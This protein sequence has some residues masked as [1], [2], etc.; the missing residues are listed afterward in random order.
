MYAT[1]HTDV[2]VVGSGIAGLRSALEAHRMGADVMIVSKKTCGL[3]NSSALSATL[4]NIPFGKK[5]V[6]KHLEET[7]EAG[8]HINNRRL[9]QILVEEA[10]QEVA[11]LSEF[12][13]SLVPTPY[14]GLMCNKGR[15]PLWGL[16]LTLP[17][18]EAVRRSQIEILDNTIVIDILISGNRVKGLVGFIPKDNEFIVIQAKSV[19]LA[20]GGAGGLYLRSDNPI[21]NTGDGYAIAYRAGAKLQDM[22]FVQ[23]FPMATSVE[24]LPTTTIPG[25][26]AD[27]GE[28]VNSSGE[29]IVRKHGLRKP[30]AIRERDALSRTIFEEILRGED[31]FIDLRSLDERHWSAD[32]LTTSMKDILVK[33][34]KCYEKPI[35]IAPICH[36]T[37]GGISINEFCETGINGLYAAG[38]VAGG[39]HGANRLGGNSLPDTL[40]FG[41]RAGVSANKFCKSKKGLKIGAKEVERLLN[42]YSFLQE[43]QSK[44]TIPSHDIRSLLRSIMWEKVGIIRS[45]QDIR[46]AL[47]EIKRVRAGKIPKMMHRSSYEIAGCLETANAIT[48][49][50]LIAKSALYRTESRGAHFRKDHPFKDNN[51]LKNIYAARKGMWTK[52]IS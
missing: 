45:E 2:V 4:F 48:V 11:G 22:E 51:W 39:I 46:N 21:F 23:F 1:F 3:A 40:V 41:A 5:T 27:V 6:K 49:S 44:S 7:L 28:I 13:I 14:G 30:I 31:V 17:M 26:F 19:I 9:V 36:Y 35:K 38:E 10:P 18:V 33:R 37:M 24:G 47:K 8:H 29:N 52:R 34:F 16:E 43:S 12:G 15:A 20:T 42:K 25:F 32:L 50:I